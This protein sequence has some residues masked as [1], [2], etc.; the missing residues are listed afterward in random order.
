V[1]N[2]LGDPQ[3][4]DPKG[5]ALGERAQLGTALAEEGTGGYCWQRDLTETFAAPRALESRHNLP[6]AVNR[7]TIVALGQVGL[8]EVVVWQHVQGALPADRGERKSTLGS[9][10][11]LVIRA[12]DVEMV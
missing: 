4:F 2:R 1:I 8:A 6:E 12:H 10:Y 9:G 7:P 3:P 11:G 5:S